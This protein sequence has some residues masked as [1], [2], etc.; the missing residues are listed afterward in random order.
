MQV[1]TIGRSPQ[2]DIVYDDN[3]VS[4]YHL[5]I[6]KHD[7]GSFELIDFDSTNGT[8][9][10]GRRVKQV[11]INS[12]DVI[13]IGTSKPLKWKNFFKDKIKE[14]I[15]NEEPE[16]VSDEIIIPEKQKTS[17]IPENKT[18]KLN[19]ISDSEF[20]QKTKEIKLLNTVFLISFFAGFFLLLVWFFINMSLDYVFLSVPVMILSGILQIT[21]FV[22]HLILLYRAWDNIQ[23]AHFQTSATPGQAVGNLFIPFYNLYWI[24]IAYK[25]LFIEINKF[26]NTKIANETF[27]TFTLVSS[28]IPVWNYITIILW[29]ILT[30]EIHKLTIL[31]LKYKHKNSIK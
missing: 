27:V 18:K 17:P 16:T 30:N 24:F 28:L 6:I 21:A 22:L 20:E 29:P 7:N 10:N 3:S 2:N 26:T 1:V 4:K 25:K 14:E 12:N 19:S 15:I 5:Q 9:V 23:D 13:K 11:T 31:T 8:F